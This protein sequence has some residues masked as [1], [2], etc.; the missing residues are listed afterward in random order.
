MLPLPWREDQNVINTDVHKS[1]YT[2]YSNNNN[3]SINTDVHK[4][5]YTSYSNKLGTHGA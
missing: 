1:W 5:W 3:K 4:S 2:S